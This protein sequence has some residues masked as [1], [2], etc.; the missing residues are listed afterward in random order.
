[1]PTHNNNHSHYV[2][3]PT[4]SGSD[5]T[6]FR[7]GKKTIGIPA[8]ACQ[9]QPIQDQAAPA[10]AH[11]YIRTYRQ[12]HE[13]V[14]SRKNTILRPP[15]L[16]ALTPSLEST[17]YRS[18]AG[19]LLVVS[20]PGGRQSVLRVTGSADTGF[21][22]APF[23]QMSLSHSTITGQCCHG[24]SLKPV[25]ADPN[26]KTGSGCSKKRKTCMPCDRQCSARPRLSRWPHSHRIGRHRL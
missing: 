24:P 11:L 7:P 14:I 18:V 25:S 10:L 20:Q 5:H 23:C 26:G 8:I 9:C 12:S 2:Y 13:S 16:V 21:R 1:M 22:P 4:R 6:G 17:G 19:G 3:R 15:P